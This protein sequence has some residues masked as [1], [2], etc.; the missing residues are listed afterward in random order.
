LKLQA[1]GHIQIKKLPI[2]TL[3]IDYYHSSQ[4]AKTGINNSPESAAEFDFNFQ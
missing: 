1:G 2:E 3:A 4:N